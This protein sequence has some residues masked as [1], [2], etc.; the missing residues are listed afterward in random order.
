MEEKVKEINEEKTEGVKTEKEIRK[1]DWR[2]LALIAFGI[3]I[4]ALIIIA[5]L[6]K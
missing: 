3:M 4:I 1:I 5:V 2:R 6:I